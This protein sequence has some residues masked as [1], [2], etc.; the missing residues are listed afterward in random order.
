MSTTSDTNA[1][2]QKVG[3]YGKIQEPRFV[4]A[5]LTFYLIFAVRLGNSG[6]KVSRIILGSLLHA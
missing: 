2:T 5:S 4:V 3:Q 1:A 6:L